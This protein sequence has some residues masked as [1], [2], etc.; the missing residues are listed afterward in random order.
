MLKLYDYPRSGNGHK[1]RLLLSMLKLP[2]ESIY[3]D[4]LNGV[5]RESWFA[6]LNPLQ[7]IPVLTDGA[8]TVQDSQAI[9]VYVASRYGKHWFSDQPEEMGRIVEWL[10]F[11]AKEIALSLQAARVFHLIGA[12]IDIEAASREGQR[13]L[14][15]LDSRLA[16]HNWLCG[17]RPTIADLACFPYVGLSREG[18][19]PLDDYN[20]VQG[21]IGRIVNLEGYVSM[22]GLPN[23]R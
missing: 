14:A 9:L 21:W 23:Q 2:Y 12:D 11:A 6:N 4:V 22:E 8:F 20:H 15:L 5:T 19:F 3:V 18:K 16:D 13:A 17:V 1:V 10:S 7:Q